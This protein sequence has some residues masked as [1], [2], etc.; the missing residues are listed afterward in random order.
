M[1]A[2]VAPGRE[3][4]TITAEKIAWSN[5][6]RLQFSP[7]GMCHPDGSINQDFFKPKKII[8]QLTED[9]KWGEQ[10]KNALYKVNAN[11]APR[12][13]PPGPRSTPL[14]R[15]PSLAPPPRAWRSTAWAS[16]AR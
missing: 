16:G 10:E 15:R 11:S 1:S 7:E 2:E 5:K 8:I 12:C 14:T 3:M 6:M 9:K 4:D 13:V